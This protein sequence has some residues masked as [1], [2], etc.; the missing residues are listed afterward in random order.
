MRHSN[1][2]INQEGVCMRLESRGQFWVQDISFKPCTSTGYG[3]YELRG[4]TDL[5][6]KLITGNEPKVPKGKVLLIS[7][8]PEN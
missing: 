6:V 1:G 7:L 5:N 2:H 8:V 4:T 3:S